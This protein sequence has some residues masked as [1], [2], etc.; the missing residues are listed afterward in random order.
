[1]TPSHALALALIPFLAL[2]GA[3]AA[4]WS[5]RVRDVFFFVMVT[6][7]VVSERME[8][9]FFSQA[10]YRGTTRGLQITLIEIVAF[11]LLLGCWLG[12]R[13]DAR[14]WFWPASFGVMLA[15]FLYAVVSVVT[16]EPKPFGAFELSRML[17]AM[18]IFLA[19]AAYVRTRREWTL[20][21]IALG[22][23]VGF[24][25]LWALKQ[26]FITRLDRVAGTLDH[27][28]SLSMYLCLTVPPL[29]AGAFGGWSRPLR[30]FCAAAAGLGTVGVL[31]TLS[32]AGIPVLAVAILGVIATCASWRLTASRIAVRAGLLLAAVALLA[33]LW[34]K[35]EERYATATLEEEYFDPTIDGRGIYLRLAGLIVTDHFFGVG[36]NNW[37]Y[38]VSRT[39]G[40]RLGFRFMDYDYLTSIYG[41]AD[42]EVYA[43]S[44]LAAPAHNLAALTLG[45]LGV[46]G[47]ALFALLWGRWFW[48]GAAF[49]RLPRG[50]PMRVLGVG[51]FFG[52]CGIFGQSLTEWVY[53]QTPILYTFYIMLAALAS[54]TARRRELRNAAP[55]IGREPED[56]LVVRPAASVAGR[57]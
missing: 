11:G 10:W 30:W 24:E 2:A 41:T 45:E 46:P 37:S 16:S 8:V 23:V 53:R 52:V 33:V 35:I 25:G 28:N 14:R 21:L 9:N 34:P 29:V 12:R 47:L 51:L 18:I 36:L 31:L 44:Y 49:I 54:L 6:L 50:E 57:V 26:R 13:D 17:G 7:A 40:Q 38:H 15:Y 43:N 5:Q 1:M 32:R 42:D 56:A 39:Y 27:A 22:C 48:M 55:A 19:A 4:T 3:V 20:L